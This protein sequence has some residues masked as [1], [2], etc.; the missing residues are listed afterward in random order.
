[1]RVGT[2]SACRRGLEFAHSA[3]FARDQ[4][5]HFSVLAWA[6]AHAS[7]AAEHYTRNRH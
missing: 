7:A 2:S 4:G 6:S 3:P 1:M 5:A